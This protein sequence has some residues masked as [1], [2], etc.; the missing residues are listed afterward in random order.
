MKTFGKAVIVFDSVCVGLEYVLVPVD[1]SGSVRGSLQQEIIV[2]VDTGNQTSAQFG[3]IQRVHEYHLLPNEVA[4]G[5]I[6]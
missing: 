4:E 3:G 1:L 5:S 2:T 6:T